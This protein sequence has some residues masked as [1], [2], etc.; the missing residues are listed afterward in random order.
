MRDDYFLFCFFLFDFGAEKRDE[1][2]VRVV[3]VV[4][5]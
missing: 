2:N 3:V 4:A 5:V 1:N